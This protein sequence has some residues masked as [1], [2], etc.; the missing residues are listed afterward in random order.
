MIFPQVGSASPAILTC[1][2][3]FILPQSY[4]FWPFTARWT[5][6]MTNSPSLIS[7]RLIETKVNMIL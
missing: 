5:P 4:D 6:A 3:L 1:I 2:L 7:W